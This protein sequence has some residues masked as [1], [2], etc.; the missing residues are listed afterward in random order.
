MQLPTIL[1]CHCFLYSTVIKLYHSILL[2]DDVQPILIWCHQCFWGV[3]PWIFI[4][5]VH[6]ILVISCIISFQYKMFH[7]DILQPDPKNKMSSLLVAW[8]D[9]ENYVYQDWHPTLWTSKHLHVSGNAKHIMEICKF[10]LFDTPQAICIFITMSFIK[11]ALSALLYP[12][13]PPIEYGAP[14]LYHAWKHRI[15]SKIYKKWWGSHSPNIS[16]ISLLPK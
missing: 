11:I 12:S 8:Q 2:Q 14:P 10:Q 6:N 16:L 9:L 5:H 1:P 13:S 4:S 7:A 15:I 3:Y